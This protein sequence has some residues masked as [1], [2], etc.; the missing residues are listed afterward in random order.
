MPAAGVRADDL[1]ETLAQALETFDEGEAHLVLDRTFASLGLERAVSEVLM[2]Y[3][4]AVGER[5]ARGELTVG[6]EHFASR[7]IEGRLLAM[8]RGWNRAPGPKAVLACPPGEQHTLPLIAFGLVLRNRGWRSVYLGADAPPSTVL[9][10][11]D[12]V[13]PE[14]LVM[15]AARTECFAPV[16]RQLS[17]LATK[18]TLLLAG[19]GAT[20]EIVARAHAR[21][22]PGD[23]VEAAERLSLERVGMVATPS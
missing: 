17:T 18:A 12:T 20:P 3:L 22:L 7:L 11:V 16:V 8:A 4:R 21:P 2:P 5:W 13:E 14:I 15:S 19:A 23:P 1:A 9:M 6:Q 10:A